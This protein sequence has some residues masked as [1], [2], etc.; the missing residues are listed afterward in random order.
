MEKGILGGFSLQAVKCILIGVGG[1]L[2]AML[3]LSGLMSLII[4]LSPLLDSNLFAFAIIIEALAIF[5]GSFLA[6]RMHGSRGLLIGLIT[7]MVIFLLLLIIGGNIVVSPLLKL[8]YC[9]ICGITGGILGI[10]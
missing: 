9:L 2:A 3:V 8:S 4:Y 6:A 10:R 7:G 1:A 5:G